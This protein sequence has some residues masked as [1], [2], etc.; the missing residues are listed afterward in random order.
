MRIAPGGALA[1]ALL[2]VSR[3][4]VPLLAVVVAAALA[5]PAAAGQR[6]PTH[7]RI[8]RLAAP[9]VPGQQASLVIETVDSHGQPLAALK[10]LTVTLEGVAGLTGTTQATVEPGSS[11]VQVPLRPAKAGLWQVEARAEGLYSASTVVVSVAPE[12]L[13]SHQAALGAAPPRTPA[14][15]SAV[16][17]PPAGH[18]APPP[19][20][21]PPPARLAHAQ[22][23]L[24]HAVGA[25]MGQVRL[26]PE[27]LE[28]SRGAQGWG[29][30]DVDAYWYE[31]GNPSPSP[32]QL[33][34]ALVAEG[35]DL[36]VAPTRL[37]ILPGDFMTKEPARVTAA[38]PV[39]ATLQ[40]L[41]PGG[42]SNQVDVSFVAA[43]GTRLAFASGS[44]QIRAFGVATSEVYVRVV[45]SAGE[46]AMAAQPIPITLQVIGPT[47]SPAMPQMVIPAGAYEA[48]AQL[49]LPRFGVYSVV[50]SAPNLNPSDPLSMEVSFDWLLLLATLVG[51]LLGSL[52]RVLYRGQADEEA[53]RRLLRVLLLGGLAALLVV[54]LSAFGLLSLLAGALPQGW[55]DDLSA[56]PL[57]SLT[58]DFLL[59]FLAGLLFDKIFGRLV[60]SPA[61]AER[62]P[63]PPR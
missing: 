26:I 30:V 41:Y 43:P 48:G 45:D 3:P 53:P 10:P 28:R 21:P 20:P 5:V 8:P 25:A 11:T 58:G 37:S 24:L 39:R 61:S 35:G 34:L 54:L 57:A 49:T 62:E 51:G 7:L 63:A 13:R 19:P 23:E 56:V 36:Q 29:P 18:A 47:G 17:I 46:P 33:E 60:A 22:V 50:A 1:A 15:S 4:A 55:A 31:N 16:A 12:V 38:A 40:V 27:H 2:A 6:P 9:L 52:T 14:A 44:R 42:Q 59:G 32:R